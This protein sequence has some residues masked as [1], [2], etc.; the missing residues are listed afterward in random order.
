[1]AKKISKKVRNIVKE[2][3]SELKND[4]DID[5]VIVFGSQVN[6]KASSASDIDV[7]IVSDFFD[8]NKYNYSYLFQKLWKVKNSNIDPVGYS[9]RDYRAK[10]PSPLLSEIRQNGL[11]LA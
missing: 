1:M 8:S 2:Y 10:T 9:P 4:I 11:E 6:G 5:R 7:A 3:V